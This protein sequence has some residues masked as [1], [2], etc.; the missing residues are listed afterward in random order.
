M[1]SKTNAGLMSA[2]DKQRIDGLNTEFKTRDDKITKNTEDIK[3][4]ND[5]MINK[6]YQYFNGKNNIIKNSINSKT[7]DM[8]IKGKTLQNIFVQNQE[9]ISQS[10]KLET[11]SS[12]PVG[13]H[14]ISSNY[15]KMPVLLKPNTTYTVI[16]LIKI[17]NNSFERNELYL[18][19]NI[20]GMSSP[21]L[22][23][24]YQ[25]DFNKPTVITS[26]SSF[27]KFTDKSLFFGGNSENSQLK[28]CIISKFNLLVIEGRVDST[29]EYFEGIKSFG[30]KERKINVLSHGKNFFNDK[31]FSEYIN[32]QGELIFKKEG[33]TKINPHFCIF[34]EKDA[35]S[36]IILYANGVSNRQFTT[37]EQEKYYLQV[38]L[39]GDK[40]DNK[41]WR[42]IMLPPNTTLYFSSKFSTIGNDTIMFKDIQIEEGTQL[43]DYKPYEE[44]Q[45]N[46]LLENLTFDEGLE[47]F[48]ENICDELNYSNKT[49]LKKV[50]KYIIN[51]S[52]D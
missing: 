22:F 9:L 24:I 45:K 36:D 47:G 26:P 41:A 17:S 30:Q 3:S 35:T 27:E 40:V 32:N 42:E 46:I 44:D 10:T 50:D 16:P 39:N 51:G 43:T 11:S 34:K 23:R 48:N 15:Y 4:W 20:S 49:A 37:I 29:L 7:T 13:L 28:S 6:E 25:R 1:A 33:N 21:S 14:S 5:E 2:S 18:Q 52:E 19:F 31:E 8:I 12:S 38:G